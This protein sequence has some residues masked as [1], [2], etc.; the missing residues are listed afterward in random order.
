M[1]RR[2]ITLI[3]IS[4]GASMALAVSQRAFAQE[5]T[6]KVMPVRVIAVKGDVAK[7]R[8]L[9]WMNDGVTGGIKDMTINRS[10]GK[11]TTM[12]FDGHAIPGDNDL[13]GDLEVTKD[14][15]GYFRLKFSNFQKYYDVYGG[16]A[17]TVTTAP[18][19]FKLAMDNPHLD[20]GDFLIEVGTPKDKDEGLDLSYERKTKSGDKSM[21]SWTPRLPATSTLTPRIVPSYMD[22]GEVTDELSLNGRAKMAGFDVS[23]ENHLEFTNGRNEWIQFQSSGV[24]TVD[25]KS[26]PSSEQL[27]SSLRASRWVIDDKTYI[28]TGYQYEHIRS[29]EISTYASGTA[30]LTSF[31]QRAAQV[32]LDSHTWVQ[33]LV[34]NF[35]PSLTMTARLKEELASTNGSGI[36]TNSNMIEEKK[37]NTTAESVSLRY[38]GIP[39]TSVFSDV[40]LQQVRNWFS[41]QGNSDNGS[42]E[43]V[44]SLPKMKAD[45]GFRYTPTS[46]VSMTSQ[47]KFKQD[48]ST[49]NNLVGSTDKG[50]FMNRLDTDSND[51]DNRVTLKPLKWFENSLQMHL[52]NTYYH[53]Q[54]IGQDWLKSQSLSR[55]YTYDAIVTPSDRWMFDFAYSLNQLKVSTPAQQ[56]LPLSIGSAGGLTD[57]S[58]TI[59]AGST[60]TGAQI[61]V[62]Q[63]NVYTL[64]FTASYAPKDN[65]SIFSS[66]EYSRAKDFNNSVQ[67]SM[68]GVDNEHYD[69]TTGI[70]WSPKKNVS[71]E[72]HYAYYSYRANQSI[73]YGNYSANVFWLDTKIS[74]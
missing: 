25:M 45:L 57:I 63:A 50:L 2:L 48:N 59:P 64:L 74:W 32:A 22:I 33:S 66:L 8:A 20:I 11:G 3:C 19:I 1:N 37:V 16:N 17:S 6:I 69:I 58:A 28:S 12:S 35:F 42:P 4:F 14:S 7:F 10:L 43:T 24:Q 41:T 23:S 15:L 46:K 39:K 38:S 36:G 62:F 31:A 18:N 54:N 34:E 27:L 68:F 29:H 49:F 21:L 40:E 13:K 26:E 30:G 65:L 53:S 72:P 56:N 55:V 52:I 5:T 51:W 71:I 61:P 67:W 70:K 47:F 60:S 73:D 44:V 9:N